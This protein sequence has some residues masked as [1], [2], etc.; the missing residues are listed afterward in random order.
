MKQSLYDLPSGQWANRF[1]DLQTQLW[2]DVRE[3]KCNLEKAL[4]LAP[5][6]LKKTKAAKTNSETKPLL[7]ARMD[8]WEAGRFVAMVKD[9]EECGMED[10]WGLSHNSDFYLE[11]AGR[12]YNSMVLSGKIRAAVCM[13][14]DRDPGGLLRPHDR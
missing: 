2:K 11:S 4:L 13:V 5:C 6:I 8:A 12:R 7:W 10:G 1:L 9:V 14:T 3:R